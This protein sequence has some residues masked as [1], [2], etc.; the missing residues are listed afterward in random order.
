MSEDISLAIPVI[1]A[2]ARGAPGRA[3]SKAIAR[4]QVVVTGNAIERGATITR[5]LRLCPLGTIVQVTEARVV[6]EMVV[7]DMVDVAIYIG[8]VP[9]E[10]ATD[11][12]KLLRAAKPDSR[13]LC[14]LGHAQGE[15]IAARALDSGFDAVLNMTTPARLYYRTIASLVQEVRRPLDA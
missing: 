3:R 13:V 10:E 8:D 14:V 11:F 15:Q 12:A 9:I 2:E 4:T 5:E 6:A 7:R 1:D